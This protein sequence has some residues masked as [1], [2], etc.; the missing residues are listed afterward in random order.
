MMLALGIAGLAGPGSAGGAG[1][2]YLGV[3]AAGPLSVDVGVRQGLL[4]GPT[5]V[6]T[7]VHLATRWQLGEHAFLRA[8]LVHQ[9]ETPW[10]DYAEH[11]VSVSLGYD[12]HIHHRTGADLGLGARWAVP[13]APVPG[14]HVSALA[15]VVGLPDAGGPRVYGVAETLVSID[16]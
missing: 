16:L 9:H 12:E 1:A 4:G 5:R 13:R 2:A 14:V 6:V 10:E 7:G 3:H 15:S 8:G 11:V